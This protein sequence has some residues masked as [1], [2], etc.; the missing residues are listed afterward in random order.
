MFEG[1]SYQVTIYIDHKNL[2]YFITTRVFNCYQARWNMLLSWFDF[3]ITYRPRKQ[4]GLFDAL[5]RR[6]YLGP[7]EGEAT[8]EQ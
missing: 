1:A 5:S 6:S 7:K 2:K 8:Y 3:V 4:Q